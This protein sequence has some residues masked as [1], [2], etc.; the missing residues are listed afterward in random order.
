MLKVSDLVSGLAVAAFGL[1]VFLRA[2]SFPVA[3]GVAVSQSF[4]PGLI[5]A[6]LVLLGL[7]LAASALIRGAALPLGGRVEWVRRP[8]NVVAVLSVPAAI[9]CYGLLSQRLGFIATS[10]LVAT[11]LLLAFRVRAATS[12]AVAF[13]LTAILYAVFV[14]MSRVPLPYGVIEAMLP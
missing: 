1:A 7:A 10:F 3:G 2:Q 11:G 13:C 6:A 8:G 4:Y 9:L 5:G 14:R 12:L